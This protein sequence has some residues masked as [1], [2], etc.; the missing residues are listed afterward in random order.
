MK[1][2]EK[3]NFTRN[4]FLSWWN[5]FKGWN[6]V[7][8]NF[9]KTWSKVIKWDAKKS[10]GTPNNYSKIKINFIKIINIKLHN[11]ISR[12]INFHLNGQSLRET[13]TAKNVPA[14]SRP[15]FHVTR[16]LTQFH[17]S[18]VQLNQNALSTEYSK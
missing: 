15:I 3:W 10:I 2:Y 17:I 13:S 5:H 6:G 9:H 1:F 16:Y 12:K 14:I 11:K 8:I 18:L 7:L 4:E